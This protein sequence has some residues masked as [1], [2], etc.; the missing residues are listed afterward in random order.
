MIAAMAVGVRAAHE[1]LALQ[2]EPQSEQCLYQD[3]EAGAAV[4]STVMVYRG[5]KLD[6]QFRIESPKKQIMYQKL[7][8]S[9]VDDRSG[10]LLPTIVRKG[11]AF[12]A[13]D[14]G[15]YSFCIDNRMAR[16]TAKVLEFHLDVKPPTAGALAPPPMSGEIVKP[17][18]PGAPVPEGVAN[19]PAVGTPE[20]ASAEDAA[21]ALQ[22][23]TWMRT[24]ASK[25]LGMLSGL[26]YDSQYHRTR[27]NRH[28][29]TLL[30]TERRVAWWSGAE[31]V[32]ILLVAAIEVLVV[33]RWFSEEPGAA[34]GGMLGSLSARSGVSSLPG[35]ARKPMLF[36]AHPSPGRPA[37]GV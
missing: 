12:V 22:H 13:P 37:F 7:I 1:M 32:A 18:A 4:E 33:R 23:M 8:F 5:G 29:A 19:T 36:P 15:V 14:T 24:H 9:N 31:T 6:V 16:W 10:M 3:I 25:L 35:S 17:A 11:H 34:G 30:S 21:S 2:V 28:H 20:G 27:S 26:V